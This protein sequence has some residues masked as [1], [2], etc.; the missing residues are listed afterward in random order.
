MIKVKITMIKIMIKTMIKIT[1][2]MGQITRLR[3]TTSRTTTIT[4][5]MLTTSQLITITK[6]NT[7]KITP[8]MTSTR[9]GSRASKTP[10]LKKRKA[11]DRSFRVFTKIMMKTQHHSKMTRG[12]IF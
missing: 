5:M 7:T 3:I 10:L 1:T 12:M 11:I 8:R 9:N 6:S 4:T 2:N